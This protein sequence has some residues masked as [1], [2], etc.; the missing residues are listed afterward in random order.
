MAERRQISC[1]HKT[2]H[3]DPYDRIRSVGG[4]YAG[5]AWKQSQ[6]QAIAELKAGTKSYYVNVGGQA[7]DV[8]VAQHSGR[9]YLKTK[10]DGLH[11]NNLLA[12]PE[13]P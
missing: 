7:V 1:I 10:P 9:D 8:I 2:V 12:L 5:T 13:C 11:P 3:T 6:P 4:T